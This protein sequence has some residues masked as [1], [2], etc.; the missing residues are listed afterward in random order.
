MAL[1]KDAKSA[2]HCEDESWGRMYDRATIEVI[3]GTGGNGSASLRHEKN[4]AKGGPDGGDGG[5]GGS[6]YVEADESL[7]TLH[8]FRYKR[9]FKAQH[10]GQ[11]LKQKQHGKA[12]ED[13]VLKVPAGTVVHDADTGETLADLTEH[14][15]RVM[16]ARGGRGGLGNTHFKT[17]SYQTPRFAE[18]GEP[19]QERRLR[20]ELKLLA[21]VALVGFPNA[22]KSTLLSTISAATPKIGNY[23]FTT[24]EPVLGVVAV[25]GSED[26]FVVADIPG[27]V[28]GAHE[29]VGLGDEF[30]RHI[31]RTRVL[32]YVVD[33]SG[34]EGR[35]P[36]GDFETLQRE[37]AAYQPEMA[38][39]PA[40]VAFNKVD[41]PEA[42]ENLASFRAQIAVDDITVLA[43]SGA[44]RV[45]LETLVLRLAQM[46]ESA[47][48]PHRFAPKREQT[49]L[50]PNPVDS[51]R[52]AIKRQAD[53]TW[54]VT[55]P[56]IERIAV[57]TD[58]ENDEAVRRLEREL[59]RLGITR[60]LES[61]G[62]QYG[63]VLQIGA[64]EIDW[65]EVDIG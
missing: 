20:F 35:S 14:G 46:L 39:K 27:L 31:E 32:L 1:I 29:G 19:G 9:V 18:R 62:I 43:V 21:D 63:D 17:S 60:A 34:Q 41:M 56:T 7:N 42:Q 28:E 24:L 58:M 23:P 53:G 15:E 54:H 50:H 10:G 47:P 6:V 52:F 11:G 3:A 48:P 13:L 2:Q 4:A 59:N 45:G 57:M 64:V 51:S 65:G 5:R 40:L 26:S 12:A 25:P 30:L 37:L 44:A 22:G 33:G 49:V 16:V 61:A 55:G 8:T 38:Q 36:V